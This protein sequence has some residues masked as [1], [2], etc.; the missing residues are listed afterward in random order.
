MVSYC[1]KCGRQTPDDAMMCP[2]CGQNISQNKISTG[3]QYPMHQMQQPQEKEKTNLGLIIAIILIVVVVVIIAISATVYVYV[4]GMMEP[5]D[6]YDETP[7][8]A[9]VKD[10]IQD[11]L[12]VAA[13]DPASLNWEDLGID[14]SC[15]TTGLTGS[16]TAGEK[17]TN[18]DGTITIIHKATNTLL[19]S[20]EF[21]E[22]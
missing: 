6:G 13:S 20:W 16:I 1:P 12:T 10:D 21:N 9:F 17:I 18:C 19:G 3:P 14:G 2:Y 7:N 11:T 5:P 22:Y 4:S 8:I 15:D